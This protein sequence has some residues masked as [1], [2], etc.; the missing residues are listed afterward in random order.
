MLLPQRRVFGRYTGAG[1]S[2]AAQ[3][4]AKEPG[5]AAGNDGR[6]V[7]GRRRFGSVSPIL[8]SS[9]P[10]VRNR[11]IDAADVTPYESSSSPPPS[12]T[13]AITTAS[14]FSR[15]PSPSVRSHAPRPPKT[16]PHHL[17]RQH[18]QRP[19]RQQQSAAKSGA[20]RAA[21]A[22]N[23]KKDAAAATATATTSKHPPPQRP[24]PATIA[25]AIAAASEAGTEGEQLRETQA[26]LRA[27]TDNTE[28]VLAELRR[29]RQSQ[30]AQIQQ[31][32]A[33]LRATDANPEASM[34]A[35]AATYL[36]DEPPCPPPTATTTSDSASFTR[37]AQLRRGSTTSASSSSTSFAGAVRTASVMQVADLAERSAASTALDA[38]PAATSAA[39]LTAASQRRA[40]LMEEALL[41]KVKEVNAQ[42]QKIADLTAANT[43]LSNHLTDANAALEAAAASTTRAHAETA[44]QISER[45]EA[46]LA[47]SVAAVVAEEQQAR[48]QLEGML[49][50]RA[51]QIEEL[52]QHVMQ[53]RAQLDGAK[54]QAKAQ[55][56]P[57][58]QIE[59]ELYEQARVA[60]EAT[61]NENINLRAEREAATRAAATAASDA[62]N[63][64]EQ[65]PH[66]QQDGRARVRAHAAGDGVASVSFTRD[67]R[68][69]LAA[70]VAKRAEQVSSLSDELKRVT[71][72]RT[73]LISE[74]E[75]QQVQ[76][77]ELEAAAAAPPQLF[78]DGGR[79]A[80]PAPVM[81]ASA[82]AMDR[83]S[84]LQERLQ[85]RASA[86]EDNSTPAA[87]PGEATA[88]CITNDP[89]TDAE[90][91]AGAQ[92]CAQ[93]Q[94]A[95]N[96]AASAN[97]ALVEKNG[98]LELKVFSLGR[99]LEQ[100]LQLQGF[101][102]AEAGALREAEEAATAHPADANST[103]AAAAEG[104]GSAAVTV[105][106][107]DRLWSKITEG[108][109][110]PQPTPRPQPEHGRH[111][112]A[113]Q[114]IS[115]S[116][117]HAAASTGSEHPPTA[118]PTNMEPPF[119]TTTT[120]TLQ[121]ELERTR[122]ELAA[123]G[124]GH[125]H[126][127]WANTTASTTASTTAEAAVQ[128]EGESAPR[129]SNDTPR[130]VAEL[131]AYR[132][133]C[134]A[135][136]EAA[137]TAAARAR[138]AEQQ[139]ADAQ[140]TLAEQ[141]ARIRLLEA[142]AVAAAAAA[143]PAPVAA[144]ESA[145]PTAGAA[146]AEAVDL[147]AEALS[148]E[149]VATR[150]RCACLE[151]SGKASAAHATVLQHACDKE[152]AATAELQARV[153]AME[154]AAATAAAVAAAQNQEAL[155]GA[156]AREMA[157]RSQAAQSAA[158]T[159][160][161]TE[162][163]AALSTTK[164]QVVALQTTVAHGASKMKEMERTQVLIGTAHAE[165][166]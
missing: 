60:L 81:A 127:E 96:A 67:Q 20:A 142:A 78:G 129:P 133:R 146:A 22:R 31:L 116:L 1:G 72:D 36:V 157:E 21:R 118:T 68:E 101:D 166:R 114:N 80:V 113:S 51:T 43:T 28:A 108:W 17:H 84:D 47:S 158:A 76:I 163:L 137:E 57:L 91:I 139:H 138:A 103:A 102:A 18:Q 159:A 93:L 165:G 88:A 2:A 52:V 62:R 122:A 135:L 6:A 131:E 97:A 149:L 46:A 83:V 156:E 141:R 42:E 164:E 23:R 64:P 53:L 94:S 71:A 161:A 69:Q 95:L 136:V 56:Q 35:L 40:L 140:A 14:S 12:S 74:N 145:Q 44:A 65:H 121:S 86:R 147:D 75:R 155:R 82:A 128:K 63:A 143:A 104:S 85:L 58:N 152:R 59:R 25:D 153:G 66:P 151:A 29:E 45:A 117:G 154:A 109:S 92:K 11:V 24:P 15:I 70:L 130:W 162:A 111:Q 106:Q 32:Q 73:V 99:K 105:L 4:R 26:V 30:K 5:N 27:L 37:A 125:I 124:L 160:K 50:N 144:T 77:A 49:G 19:S 98:S 33:R 132:G 3:S 150:E 123:L 120:I 13:A 10:A 115:P 119:T 54:E 8:A 16:P 39:S 61:V 9:P 134:T 48:A 107:P 38:P 89:D 79:A 7:R 87:L 110:P 90:L 41:A 100:Q 126:R 34:P 112:P 55:P 148:A